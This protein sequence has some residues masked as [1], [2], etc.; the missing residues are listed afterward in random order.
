M[1]IFKDSDSRFNFN[2]FLW[3]FLSFK[4]KLSK[5]VQAFCKKPDNAFDKNKFYASEF[6]YE[7]IL[8]IEQ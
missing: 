2:Q 7:V 3:S 1:I 4:L 8:A 5:L 6:C